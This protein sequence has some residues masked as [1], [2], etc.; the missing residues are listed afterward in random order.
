MITKNWRTDKTLAESDYNL[1]FNAIDG[2]YVFFCPNDIARGVNVATSE[3]DAYESEIVP[4]EEWQQAGYDVHSV[5]ADPMFVDPGHEDYRLK[6]E[7]PA[8]K[9]GFVPIDV[10]R[11]GPM[12]NGKLLSL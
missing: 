9:L 4:F 12:S 11:I 10:T 3:R 1:F 2:K 8:L 7:S 5:I 6:P